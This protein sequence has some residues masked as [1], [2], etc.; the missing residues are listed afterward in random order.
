MPLRTFTDR[1][2]DEWRVWSVVPEE[3]AALTLDEEFRA[4]WLC[5]ER[6]DGGERRRLALSDVPAAWEALPDER[7]DLLRRVALLSAPLLLDPA[8]VAVHQPLEDEARARRSGPRS[9]VGGDDD[10]LV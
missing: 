9:A 10:A 3:H 5:F 2:G 7:L 1:K 4:G 6:M 8:G